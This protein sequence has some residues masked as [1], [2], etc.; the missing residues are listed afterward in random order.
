MFQGI[1][2]EGLTYHIKKIML[3]LSAEDYTPSLIAKSGC[4]VLTIS[5]GSACST[6]SFWTSR[7]SEKCGE[8]VSDAV[9]LK[10]IFL[11]HV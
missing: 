7:A 5:D 11:F 8:S 1:N 4:S 6:D 3:F 10:E 2:S 9:E